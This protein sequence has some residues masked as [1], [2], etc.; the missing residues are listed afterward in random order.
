[1]IKGVMV[2]SKYSRELGYVLE[3]NYDLGLKEYGIWEEW[4]REEL[5]KRIKEDQK[6]R[7]IGFERGKLFKERL[8]S[9]MCEIM[10]KQCKVYDELKEKKLREK[11]D[12]QEEINKK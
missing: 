10:G 1:M 3:M 6:F 11:K 9:R 12:I 2:L 7:E 4:E 5:N 8:K